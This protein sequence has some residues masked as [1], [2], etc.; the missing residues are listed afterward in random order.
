MK[1]GSE[2]ICLSLWSYQNGFPGAGVKASDVSMTSWG[3]WLVRAKL[4]MMFWVRVAGRVFSLCQYFRDNLPAKL[5]ELFV[6][7]GMVVS[8]F[9]VV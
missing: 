4:A 8:Q 5:R 2:Q 1:L 9:V 6:P 3:R 7:S